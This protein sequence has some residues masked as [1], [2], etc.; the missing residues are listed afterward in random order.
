MGGAAGPTSLSPM[1]PA[2]GA[3]GPGGAGLPAGMQQPRLPSSIPLS[4]ATPAP[5]QS[6]AQPIGTSTVN[7]FTIDNFLTTQA[8][9]TMGSTMIPQT[10]MSDPMADRDQTSGE[11]DLPL[12]LI[13]MMGALRG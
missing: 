4:P 1:L 11:S 9:S 5:G 7:P 13:R 6:G 2:G 10:G 3:S 12:A 8:G